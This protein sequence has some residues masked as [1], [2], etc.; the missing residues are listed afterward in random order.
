[1][2]NLYLY[3]RVN[4]ADYLA[5]QGGLYYLDYIIKNTLIHRYF[6]ESLSIFC[7]L[8]GSSLNA[9]CSLSCHVLKTLSTKAGKPEKAPFSL[10]S[11]MSQTVTFVLLRTRA[12]YSLHFA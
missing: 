7:L 11:F 8:F 6:A 12:L 4:N 9:P 10:I 3:P 2:T 1:M 5:A